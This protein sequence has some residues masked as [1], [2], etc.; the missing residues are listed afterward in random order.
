MNHYT[1]ILL[2]LISALFIVLGVLLKY[3]KCYGLISGYNTMSLEKK[4]N[5]DIENLSRFLAHNSFLMAVLFLFGSLSGFIGFYWGPVIVFAGLMVISS[6]M[7]IGAQRYDANTRNAQGKTKLSVFLMVGGFVL[8]FIAVVVFV[9][10][11][12][13]E[14]TAQINENEL[15]ITGIYG[16]NIPVR[17]IQEICL[18]EALP[19]IERKNNGFDLGPILKGYFRVKGHGVA[20]LILRLDSPP[21]I[22][23]MH[24]KKWIFFN[25]KY[26]EQTRRLYQQIKSNSRPYRQ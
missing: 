8:F 4:Q 9:I 6:V 10:Y 3:F 15:Q 21:F 22:Q 7:L 13:L 20:K 1:S 26:P 25:V 12:A 14:P 17:K 23:L 18:I 2:F 5:V 11:G 19:E 16:V 24:N